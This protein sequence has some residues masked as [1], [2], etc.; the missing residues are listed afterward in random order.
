MNASAMRYP[1][2]RIDFAGKTRL[3]HGIPGLLQNPHWHL[4]TQRWLP[5]AVNHAQSAFADRLDQP[6]PSDA[7][8]GLNAAQASGQCVVEEGVRLRVSVEH[9]E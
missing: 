6:P 8:A 2:E 3:S 9:L 7:I 1:P 5:G 4:Q